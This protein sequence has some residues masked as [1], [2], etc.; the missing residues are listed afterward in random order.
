MH[1]FVTISNFIFCS[2]HISEQLD[3]KF[4]GNNNFSSVKG[5]FKQN[6]VSELIESKL[7]LIVVVELILNNYKFKYINSLQ[8]LNK[9]AIEFK[10][11]EIKVDKSKYFNLLHLKNI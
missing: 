3:V 11:S 9:L 1:S 2:K 6:F 8:F 10:L 5:S 7:E 4:F